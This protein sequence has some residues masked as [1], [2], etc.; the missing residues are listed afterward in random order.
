[1]AGTE[2]GTRVIIMNNRDW[3]TQFILGVHIMGGRSMKQ[4]NPQLMTEANSD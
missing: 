1:M 2:E 3:A 4:P